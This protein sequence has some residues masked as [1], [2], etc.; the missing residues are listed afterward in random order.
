MKRIISLLCLLAL[1]PLCIFFA[2][3]E[4]EPDDPMKEIVEIWKAIYGEEYVVQMPES[5]TYCRIVPYQEQKPNPAYFSY[6]L[7]ALHSD[8]DTLF[9][10]KLA[11]LGD[12]TY[13]CYTDKTSYAVGEEITVYMANNSEHDLVGGLGVRD[14]CIR[15]DGVWYIL[16]R[17]MSYGA[18]GTPIPSG[19]RLAYTID[20]RSI[21]TPR[22]D[23]DAET[24]KYVLNPELPSFALPAGYYRV[25]VH[26]SPCEQ[27]EGAQC[28]FEIK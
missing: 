16:S 9:F 1:V 15:I 21:F 7:E 20:D 2:G 27:Y 12:E 23:Y 10:E 24:N 22:Y 19:E 3:C 4:K 11:P 8:K 13:K 17:F 28:E 5:G 26:F 6:T 25:T 18:T 14:I